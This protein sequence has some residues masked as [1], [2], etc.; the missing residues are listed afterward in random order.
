MFL[1][2]NPLLESNH[3][4]LPNDVLLVKFLLYGHETLSVQDNTAMLTATETSKKVDKGS[5]KERVV[6]I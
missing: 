2:I 5:A 4:S 1:A 6:A 3:L